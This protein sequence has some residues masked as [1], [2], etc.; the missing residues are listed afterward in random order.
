MINSLL[1]IKRNMSSSYDARGRRVGVTVLEIQPNLVTQIKTAEGKDG[2]D[3][4]QLG[5]GHKKYLKKPQLG[6]LKKNNIDQNIRW[7]KEVRG[8]GE[9]LNPGQNLKAS[10][11]FVVGDA[12]KVSGTSK[13]RG[14]QGGMKRH[15]FHGGPKTHGQSDRHRA[16]GSIGSTTTPGRVYKGKKMAGHSGVEK[17]SV[18]NLEVISVDKTNNLLLVKGAVPG[19]NGALVVIEKLGH[20]KGH[21]PEASEE[22]EIAEEQV[23]E[24]QVDEKVVSESEVAEDQP[25]EGSENVSAETIELEDNKE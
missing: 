11:I 15:G 7:M 24:S 21:T 8:E 13:G 5:I 10:D 19:F 3:G 4:V 20:I 18:K 1:A 22:V 14:F 16:P 25:S 23:E 12:V 17:V 9:D 2:Y 6:H